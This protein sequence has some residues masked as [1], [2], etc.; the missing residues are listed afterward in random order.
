MIMNLKY[1]FVQNVHKIK[2]K[3]I[4]AVGQHLLDM[5]APTFFFFYKLC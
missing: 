3:C 4:E 2:K 5:K 1:N